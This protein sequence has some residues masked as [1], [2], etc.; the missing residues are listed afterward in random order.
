MKI[1]YFLHILIATVIYFVIKKSN[2]Q[3]YSNVLAYNNTNDGR[4]M[5]ILNEK[6][7]E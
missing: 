4:A 2:S 5:E 3:T 7:Y 1:D 6:L